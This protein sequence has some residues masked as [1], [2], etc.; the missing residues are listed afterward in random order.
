MYISRGQRS[1]WKIVLVLANSV[2]PSEI[3]HYAA[4][5]LGLHFSPKYTFTSQCIQRVNLFQF[6]NTKHAGKC[7]NRSQVKAISCRV[8]KPFLT[9][10]GVIKMTSPDASRNFPY[11]IK[12][13]RTHDLVHWFTCISG[14]T[15]LAG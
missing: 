8:K 5:H 13:A 3:P 11:F 4:F 10:A 2:D 1:Y 14:L 7:P 6:L 15:M 9:G 12:Y